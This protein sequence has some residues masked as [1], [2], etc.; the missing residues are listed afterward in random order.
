MKFTLIIIF[1][2]INLKIFSQD[3]FGTYVSNFNPFNTF[4]TRL[5]LTEDSTVYY[6]YS[7]GMYNISDTGTFSVEKDT[8]RTYFNEFNI[9]SIDSVIIHSSFVPVDSSLFV[10][11]AANIGPHC[12]LIKKKKLLIILDDGKILEK[13][14]Y[15]GRKNKMRKYFL[16]KI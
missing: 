3:L 13:S 12:F 2:F 14:L 10:N 8:L 7:G 9:D 1:L 5:T 16:E 15:E 4:N 6:E 11:Q